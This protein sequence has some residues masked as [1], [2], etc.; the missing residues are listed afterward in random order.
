MNIGKLA[1][2]ALKRSVIRDVK[3]L[4]KESNAG[5]GV[6]ASK[7]GNTFVSTQCLSG[8]EEGITELT[9]YRAVNSLAAAGARAEAVTLTLALPCEDAENVAKRAMR[10]A[11]RACAQANVNLIS[12]NTIVTANN[13]LTVSATALGRNVVLYAKENAFSSDKAEPA[14]VECITAE[15]K[16]LVMLGYTGCAGAAMLAKE[17]KKE[18]TQKL[19]E[20]FIDKAIDSFD[21]SLCSEKAFELFAKTSAIVHDVE[22]GG[23]FSAIWELCEREGVG[24]EVN[25]KD[26]PIKQVTVEICER[27]DI[28]P[29]IMRGDGAMLAIVADTPEARACGAV[30][31]KITKDN[32]RVVVIGEEKRFLEPNRTD[33]YYNITK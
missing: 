6:D 28:N 4:N 8:N 10:E 21:E 19:P 5:V 14:A 11:A 24:C 27:F 32:S 17:H 30:I 16:V 22:D 2:S 26:I 18:L 9:I 31:G 13:A 25:V 23:V 33:D 1:E 29:Y 3:K 15:G 20:D 12:G 7:C